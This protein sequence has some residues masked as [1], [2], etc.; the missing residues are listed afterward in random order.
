[1]SNIVNVLLIYSAKKDVE[2]VVTGF[3]PV[4][5]YIQVF[6]I[7]VWLFI[8]RMNKL[9]CTNLTVV[10]YPFQSTLFGSELSA[11]CKTEI[12]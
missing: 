11:L 4:K 7:C 3:K 2:I 5:E 6:C 1:M 10:V 9:N 12:P 8:G